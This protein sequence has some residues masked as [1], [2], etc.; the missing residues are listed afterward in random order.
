MRHKLTKTKAKRSKPKGNDVE[1]MYLPKSVMKFLSRFIILC[2]VCRRIFADSDN[3]NSNFYFYDTQNKN[4]F[5]VGNKKNK[6]VGENCI[7]NYFP[8]NNGV[9]RSYLG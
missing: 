6:E 9:V 8:A 2:V 1:T 7:L 3:S 5:E 4:K